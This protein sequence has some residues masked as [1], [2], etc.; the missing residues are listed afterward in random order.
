MFLSGLTP[1]LTVRPPLQTAVNFGNVND[2]DATLSSSPAAPPAFN[3]SNPKAFGTMPAGASAASAGPSGAKPTINMHSFFTGGG[4]PSPSNVP[5]VGN[6]RRLSAYDQQQQQQQQSRSP[7]PSP[8]PIPASG[9]STSSASFAPRQQ[10]PQAFVPGQPQPFSPSPS[11]QQFSQHMPGTSPYQQS[12]G[13][14][15]YMAAAG[16][17]GKTPSQNIPNGSSPFGG[18]GG[19]SQQQSS[20]TQSR[21]GSFVGSPVMQQRPQV[22]GRTSY[23]GPT[24]PRMPSVSLPQGQQMMYPQQQ[25]GGQVRARAP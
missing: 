10:L 20:G 12:A 14:S 4:S 13:G 5:G 21:S 17:A 1:T 7:Q 11:P 18:P 6:D 19:A 23:A 2:K 15:P 24:S 25:W 8:S 9:L 16:Q 3:S 22:G